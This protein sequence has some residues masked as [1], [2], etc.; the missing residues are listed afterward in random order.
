MSITLLGVRLLLLAL[1][2]EQ[3]ALVRRGEQCF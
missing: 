1:E 3:T 2:Y